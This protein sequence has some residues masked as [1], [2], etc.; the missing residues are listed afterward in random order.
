MSVYSLVNVATLVRDLARSG[1][2]VAVADELLRAFALGPADEVELARRASDVVGREQRAVRRAQALAQDDA[3]PRALSVLA[4]ARDVA[5]DLG[6]RAWAAAVDGLE[7][8]PLGDLHALRAFVRAE[9]L[10]PWW[11][12]AGDLAVLRRPD[13]ADVVADGVLAAYV[14]DTALGL[15]WRTFAAEAGVAPAPT[16]WPEVV[17]RVA[18]LPR[19]A[20]VPAPPAEWAVRMHE[21]CWAVH[22]TGRERAAAITQLQAIRAVAG[23]HAPHAPPLRVVS[24]VTAMVH[25]EVVADVLDTATHAAMTEPFLRLVP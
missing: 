14:G 7:Q 11:E 6:L 17:E 21:A 22:L 2:A 20:T 3:R 13:A 8:A 9:V 18:A 16:A 12:G 23:A 5:D 19:D 25:A 15:E 10:A 1:R 24:L 4:A